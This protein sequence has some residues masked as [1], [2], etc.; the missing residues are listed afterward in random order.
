MP[1]E[2]LIFDVDGTLADTEEIHRRA[3]NAAFLAHRLSWRW[4]R[5]R[6][7][8]LLRVPGGKERLAYFIESFGLPG[9]ETASLKQLIPAI[10]ATKTRCY[11][12]FVGSGGVT[13]RPGV[14]RLIDEARATGVALAIASTTT[15]ANV[16]SLLTNTL[17]DES[18][19]MFRVIATGDVVAEK[20]PAPDIYQLALERLGLVADSCVAFEDSEL[21]VRAS[22]AAG[23]FTVATP[24][25]WSADEDFRWANLV[26]P[27]LDVPLRC[28][29]DAKPLDLV[30]LAALQASSLRASA[31]RPAPQ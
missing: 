28:T 3:F 16:V 14:R 5:E 1:L 27:H 13:L 4:S 17:G 20:K 10:H 9:D 24:T 18:L 25:C 15:R 30:A 19:D 22:V 26:L 31:T 12:R 23:L 8:E 2:A 6:Y 11:A 29:G 21:G 7:G